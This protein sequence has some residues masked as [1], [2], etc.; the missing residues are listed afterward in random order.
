MVNALLGPGQS[1]RQARATS[2]AATTAARGTFGATATATLTA[3]SS[4]SSAQRPPQQDAASDAASSP[5]PS[6]SPAAQTLRADLAKAAATVTKLVGGKGGEELLASVRTVDAL[7]GEFHEAR[8]RVRELKRLVASSQAALAGT[9]RDLN[10]LELRKAQLT[11][12]LEEVD[13]MQ[14]VVS[15]VEA[16]SFSSSSSFS[17]PSSSFSPN[18]ADATPLLRAQN[19][20]E[21]LPQSRFKEELRSR[22][23]AAQTGAATLLRRDLMMWSRGLAEV[24]NPTASLTA[25][26]ALAGL[27]AVLE[28]CAPPPQSS[29]LIHFEL[30]NSLKPENGWPSPPDVVVREDPEVD[31]ALPQGLVFAL[32]DSRKLCTLLDASLSQAAELISRSQV[33]ANFLQAEVKAGRAPRGCGDGLVNSVWVR[34]QAELIS[35]LE[36]ATRAFSSS[37]SALAPAPPP[38]PPPPSLRTSLS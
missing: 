4:S 7:A 2:A 29:N 22:V 26:A 38:P 33:V 9:K 17:F 32:G 27:E 8:A 12:L 6:Q 31:G 3:P 1:D 14:V 37:S 5:L 11:L 18:L 25:L 30:P 36:N 23:G 35:F 24:A 28:S 19:A 13:I 10:G 21:R 15:G 34:I 16:A 20:L